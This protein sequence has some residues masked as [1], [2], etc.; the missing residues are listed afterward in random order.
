MTDIQKV[1]EKHKEHLL[2][3]QGCTAVAIALKKSGSQKSKT[4]AIVVFVAQKRRDLPADQRV[5]ATLDGIPTDV[6]ERKFGIAL[7]ATDPF[8]RHPRLFSGISVTPRSAAEVWG[9][10]GCIIQTNGNGAN[11][12]PGNYLLTNQ[13]VLKWADPTHPDFDNARIIQP[14]NADSPAP[15]NYDCGDFV[16]GIRDAS[17]DCAI[18]TIDPIRGWRNEVPN[19][20]RHPG[21]RDLQGVAVARLEDE[22]YKFGASTLNTRGRIIATHFHSDNRLIRNALYIEHE[23]H[24]PWVAEGDSGSVAILYERDLVVGLNFAGDEKTALPDGGYRAGF[25]YDIQGQMNNF[26]N[27]VMLAPNP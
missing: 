19:H 18:A 11:I 5:P 12:A 22:V 1:F 27:N 21:R 2:S 13:H 9:T 10:I 8:A 4:P 14:G 23:E 7:T 26:G 20:P 16:A 15:I 6:V 3:L 25:A 17:N 24:K